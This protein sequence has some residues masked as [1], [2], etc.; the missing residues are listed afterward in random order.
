MIKVHRK[1]AMGI[2]FLGSLLVLMIL[3]PSNK[4]SLDG[5]SGT[6]S[7]SSTD[8]YTNIN[9]IITD[10]G[11]DYATFGFF[12]Q[13]YESSLRATYFG[14]N[15]LNALG[16]LEQVNET[17]V[18]SYIMSHYD[19]D[20]YIFRDQY[21]NRYLD[22]NFSLVYYPLYSLLEV[23]CYAL[24][25]LDLLN[26]LHLIDSSKSVEFVWSCYNPYSSGFIGQPFDTELQNS[27]LISTLDNTYYA[28]KTLDLLMPSW[29]SRTQER[30]ALIQY[31]NE[32]QNTN[33]ASWK[34]GGFVNDNDT[35][36][37]SLVMIDDAN[38]FSAY[39][40]L[41]SLEVFGMVDSINTANFHQFL[42]G[43]YDSTNHYFTFT[44]MQDYIDHNI[45]TSAIGLELSDISGFGGYN[46]S[47]VLNFVL[48][49]KNTLGIW[50]SSSDTSPHELIDTFQITRSLDAT[51]DITSLGHSDTTQIVTTL[52]T[53]YGSE[54]GFTPLSTDYPT[55]TLYHSIISAF[56][57]FGRLS[58]LDIGYLYDI[59]SQA[60]YDR[61]NLGYCGFKEY[62]PQQISF[63]SFPV[64]FYSWGNRIL[65]QEIEMQR[66]HTSSYYSLDAL[67]TLFKLDDLGQQY[68][69]TW[70]LE[71]IVNAQFLNSSF[72]SQYGGFLPYGTYDKYDALHYSFIDGMSTNVFLEYT[73]YAIK[74]LELLVEFLDIGDIA[75]LDINFEALKSYIEQHI[76][77][78]HTTLYFQ[79]VYTNNIE[80]LLENTF[81]MVEVLQLI[82][83]YDLDTD[84]IESFLVQHID[85]TN[86]QNI[87]Y[88]YK[89]ADLLEL[90][91][92]FDYSLIQSLVRNCFSSEYNEFYYT[93]DMKT[94]DQEIF[95]WICEMASTDNLRIK[96][97]VPQE[98]M[99]GT[100]VTI[101]SS[102][103]NMILSYFEYDLTFTYK[104][105]ELGTFQF[106]ELDT[107]YFSLDLFIPQNPSYYPSVIG[108]IIAYDNGVKLTEQ[109]ILI[110]TIYPAR[111]FQDKISGTVVLSVLFLAI[112]GSV[113]IVSERKHKRS[114]YFGKH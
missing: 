102:L 11:E 65:Q 92:D 26:A 33:T 69:L 5:Y 101:T 84:K 79:P 100:Q 31:I 32:R 77:E 43:L 78:T 2:L 20:S 30:S 54:G 53:Y 70:L 37:N 40:A 35:H 83:K 28:L 6:A 9:A 3:S 67:Q 63:R 80:A 114:N 10:K 71:D 47:A 23:N 103:Y 49:N 111:V 112:P 27:F 106:E 72:S 29:S 86:I 93:P 64:E 51:G 82:D 7:P 13:I 110:A 89:L 48:G 107:N 34:F 12:P 36:F 39:Y 95:L 18:I 1:R 46:R 104:N 61:T 58:E 76:V 41:K 109:V 45:V 44:G 74:S 19:G 88:S 87:Y 94:K 96:V 21:A 99:L 52:L 59:I 60:F 85:Y 98:V 38:M 81:Y 68:D 24:L 62:S 91:I 105:G 4:T 55:M 66:S 90:Q 14:L 22:T 56:N 97:E 57:L 73:Y 75:F 50:D 17:E 113:I 108:K 8:N 42:S 16:K 25:S 15:T